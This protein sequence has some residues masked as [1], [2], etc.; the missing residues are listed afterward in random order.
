MLKRVLNDLD[1]SVE[2]T[3]KNP[4]EVVKQGH[5][6]KVEMHAELTNSHIARQQSQ[7]DNNNNNLQKQQSSQMLES[8]DSIL[9]RDE[10]SSIGGRSKKTRRGTRA[11]RR[12]KKTPSQIQAGSDFGDVGGDSFKKLPPVSDV[13]F[14]SY[15]RRV[16]ELEKEKA[17]AEELA[18]QMMKQMYSMMSEKQEIST[19]LAQLE[20]E[21]HN[22]LEQ[23]VYLE[24]M[25]NVIDSQ[26]D[27]RDELLNE[28]IRLQGVIDQLLQNKW[29]IKSTFPADLRISSEV[30]VPVTANVNITSPSQDSFDYENIEDLI[31]PEEEDYEEDADDMKYFVQPRTAEPI[32]LNEPDQFEDE[33]N[34]EQLDDQ[35][36]NISTPGAPPQHYQ[37]EEKEGDQ[38]LDQKFVE[39]QQL[40][41]EDQIS[42]NH[43]QVGDKGELN[44]AEGSTQG[45]LQNSANEILED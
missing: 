32:Q 12:V 29:N 21:H 6:R 7:S 36:N 13:E 18:D 26:N 10:N 19:T 45:S 37:Q 11:G 2:K 41:M 3:R 39:P 27:E 34:L 9:S 28:V 35:I 15:Q 43:Q 14:E 24:N 30:Q 38:A 42:Q 5:L 16:D 25:Q 4:L 22:T 44:Q 1:S 8:Y 23:L 31:I 33:E 20:R 17:N 40:N